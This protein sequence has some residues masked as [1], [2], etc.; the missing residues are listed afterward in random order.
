MTV[1]ELAA[2]GLEEMS[3]GAVEDCLADQ[4]TGVLGLPTDGEPYLLPLSYSYD[5]PGGDGGGSG[6]STAA[7]NDADTDGTRDYGRLY[8]TYVLGSSSRKAALTERA[9]RAR[10]LVYDVDTQFRWRSVTVTGELVPVPEE[11]LD[12]IRHVH[13][14][15]WRPS[16]LDSAATA[17]G[18]EVYEL[19]V[20]ERSGIEQDGLAPEFRENIHP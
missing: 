11:R 12:D 10:F 8:F 15:A 6:E 2:Y 1:D 7:G 5:R 14:N 20:K 9:R 18:V 19:T 13:Q 17:G 16:L 3:A 4:S